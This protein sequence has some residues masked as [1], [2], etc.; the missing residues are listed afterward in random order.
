[1]YNYQTYPNIRKLCVFFCWDDVDPDKHRGPMK[2]IRSMTLAGIR[3]SEFQEVLLSM[4]ANTQTSFKRALKYEDT[5]PMLNDWV[6]HPKGPK[7]GIDGL[8]SF[9]FLKYPAQAPGIVKKAHRP[10]LQFQSSR[11]QM[12]GDSVRQFLSH[13]ERASKSVYFCWFVQLSHVKRC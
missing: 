4:L 3:S 13:P 11:G 2:I 7:V 1:M 9:V 8:L 12:E 6:C 5:T 10:E